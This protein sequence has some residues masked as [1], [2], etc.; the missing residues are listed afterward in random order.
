MNTFERINAVVG[1]IE[2][3]ITNEIDY[4][5]AAEITC[6]PKNQFQRFFAYITEITLSEYIRRRRLTLSA[7]ELQ[8]NKLKVIDIALK[9]GYDSHTSFARAFREFHGFSPSKAR[10]KRMGFN[11]YPKLTFQVQF[12]YLERDESKVAVLGKIEFFEL[13]VF[14]MIGK[15]VVNGGGE[16]PVPALWKK[17][18]EEDTFGVLENKTLVVDYSFGW[19][20]EA[21]AKDLAFDAVEGTINYFCP[22]KR[23]NKLNL[24]I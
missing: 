17:C 9:Y 24:K 7:Y 12:F 23:I 8:Q 15:M 21:Y 5:K 16:N 2:S 1:Y 14:R 18:F 6:C 3:N 4:A 19:S 11:V 22:C 13:P 20:A 10:N